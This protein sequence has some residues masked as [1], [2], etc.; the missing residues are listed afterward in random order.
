VLRDK[1]CFGMA[2][3]PETRYAKSDEGL[4]IAYQVVGDGPQDVAL[5]SPPHCID[6][7]WED[8]GFVAV[9]SRLSRLGRLILFDW[10]GFG[11][12]DPVPLGALPTP[13]TW[14]DD[15]RVVLDAV[16]SERAHLIG[17]ATG[18]TLALLFA[19]THPNR[20]ASVVVVDSYARGVRGDGYPL[21][22]PQSVVDSW[23]D[24]MEEAWGSRDYGA[25]DVPSRA[26][27]EEY[28][29]WSARARRLT[30][31]PLAART[32]LR[33][34]SQL[35]VRAA[36]S[37][38]QVPTLV[39]HSGENPVIRIDAGRYLADHLPDARFVERRGR[40]L[41]ALSPIGSSDVLDHIEEFLTGERPHPDPDRAFA[42]ILF[43]DVV[44]STQALAEMGDERW[45]QV[46]DRHDR[47]VDRELAHFRGRMVGSMGDGVLATFDGP[48]RAVRCARAIV[49]A[50][51]PL[52]IEVRAGLH[53]GEVELR[54]NDIGGIAVHIGQRVSALAEPGEVLVSR[55]IT[56]LVAGSGLE[57]TDRG[58]QHLKGVPG[59]WRLFAVKA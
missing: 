49:D 2:P 36:L 19:A 32:T 26:D 18:G 16:G 28:L 33:W 37:S 29:D 47:I 54:G 38:V 45:K 12:S 7:G 23:L 56:D 55:T 25:V 20:A 17:N 4:H 52:G 3:A 22:A 40:D 27:D 8:P 15:L 30:Q 42:T 39:L 41:F 11:S 58:E 10:L 44:S 53:A 59:A 14:L 21:A 50:V 51:R 6:M 48:A 35:D 31:S 5:L 24:W 1:A 34:S 13:E 46:L 9:A 57:F 43:T